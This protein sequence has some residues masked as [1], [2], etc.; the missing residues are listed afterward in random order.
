MHAKMFREYRNLAEREDAQAQFNVGNNLSRGEG[1]RRDI[2]GAVYWYRRAA[3]QGFVPAQ[4]MLGIYFSRYQ[5][6][7]LTRCAPMHGLALLLSR[8][9]LTQ[10]ELEI[11]S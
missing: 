3:V 8:E 1:V 6:P 10:R 11:S 9:A 4:T 7:P 5:D 2:A